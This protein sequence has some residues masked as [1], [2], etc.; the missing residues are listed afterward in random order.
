VLCIKVC[1]AKNSFTT[2]VI[3]MGSIDNRLNDIAEIR[4]LMEQSSKFLSLSGLSGLSAGAVGIAAYGIAR[5]E[6]AGQGSEIA[7]VASLTL[8]CI[9]AVATLLC[10]LGLATYFSTRMAKRK[11]LAV[12]TAATK[13]LLVN[14]FIPLAAGGVFCATLLY[15]G[16]YSLIAPATLIFYGLALLNSSKYTLREIRYLGLSEICL[17][18]FGAIWFEYGLIFWCAGFGVLHILYG[19]YMYVKYEK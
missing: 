12:W 11:G 6:L 13:Y 1:S 9:E 16:F 2:T 8:Y 17:G 18:L 4:S 14:L 7:G 10:A 5:I 15:H 19:S 3:T